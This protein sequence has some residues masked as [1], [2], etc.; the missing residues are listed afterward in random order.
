MR[1]YYST[2]P[3]GRTNVGVDW[4]QNYV[5]PQ[6]EAEQAELQEARRVAVEVRKFYVEVRIVKFGPG[7]DI[8]EVI[9]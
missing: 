9:V 8:G 7:G 4:D 1:P 5:V 2:T 3:Q 6:L